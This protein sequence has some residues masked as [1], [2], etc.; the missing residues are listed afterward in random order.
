MPTDVKECIL[1]HHAHIAS[2]DLFSLAITQLPAND[3]LILMLAE[4]HQAHAAIEDPAHI[5]CVGEN[6]PKEF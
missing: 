4:N 6:L 5:F 3:P 2:E 1:N